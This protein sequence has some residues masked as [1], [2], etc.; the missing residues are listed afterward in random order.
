ML[1]PVTQEPPMMLHFFTDCS[2]RDP[3]LVRCLSSRIFLGPF[4]DRACGCGTDSGTSVPESCGERHNVAS[5]QNARSSPR[6]SSMW[7]GSISC[8]ECF[9][10]QN[11]KL[12]Q[13]DSQLSPAPGSLKRLSTTAGTRGYSQSTPWQ[14]PNGCGS[15]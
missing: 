4:G 1:G 12:G 15:V 3:S 8:S 14:Q 5:L 7:C 2:Y 9:R 13:R 11:A 10:E 6:R